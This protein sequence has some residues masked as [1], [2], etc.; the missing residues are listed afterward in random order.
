MKKILA[1]V[2]CLVLM[3]GVFY[4]CKNDSEIDKSQNE[5]ANGVEAAP[6]TLLT[7]HRSPKACIT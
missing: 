4:G 1:F 2:V 3:A 7:V 5:K 6:S